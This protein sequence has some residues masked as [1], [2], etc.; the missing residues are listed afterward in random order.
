VLAGDFA[1]N[2]DALTF[3]DGDGNQTLTFNTT[4]NITVKGDNDGNLTI[5]PATGTG[6]LYAPNGFWTGDAQTANVSSYIR[7]NGR[8]SGD[9]YA[10][11]DFYGSDNRGDIT[12]GGTNTGSATLTTS[13]TSTVIASFRI[14]I[15]GDFP[16]TF[17]WSDDG[18]ST[19]DGTAIFI[20]GS[21]QALGATG[22]SVTFSSTIVADLGDYW[23]FDTKDWSYDFR[24]IRGNGGINTSTG[25]SHRG[26]GPFEIE[27]FEAA[28]MYFQTTNTTR[29]YIEAGGDVGIGDTDPVE[30]LDVAGNVR[31]DSYI[32]YSPL[33]VGNDALDKIAAIQ[34]EPGA[35][36][37]GWAKVDHATLPPGVGVKYKEKKYKDKQTGQFVDIDKLKDDEKKPE[38]DE[39]TIDT[40]GRNLGKMLCIAVKAI[41][42]LKER[43]EELEAKRN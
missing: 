28:P 34:P 33:Y 4:N 12:A 5:D 37:D 22:V 24:I 1:V 31:A 11:I 42:E 18:G 23:T 41:T 25:L 36:V 38:Y 16:D 30:K 15:D 17:M 8:G 26:T 27:T 20:T 32:E 2:G 35:S 10:Y 3:G 29:L 40:D 19:W 43:V 6:V 14:E 21:A 7:L 13:G 39:V 9:R